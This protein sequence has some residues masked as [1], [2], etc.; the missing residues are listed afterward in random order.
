MIKK[1]LLILLSISLCS[2]AFAKKKEKEFE[3]NTKKFKKQNTK[4]LKKLW[5][6]SLKNGKPSK[7]YYPESSNPTLE[8]D[9]IYVGTHGKVFYAVS[10]ST[11]KII[12]EYKNDEPIASTASTNTQNVFFTD[13]GGHI[14]CL[15]KQSG[16]LVWKNYFGDELLGRPLVDK[17]SL[18]LLKGE[19]EI[20]S[21]ST[22]SGQIK[23]NKSIQTYIRDIT[24]NGHASFIK[25]Q[26]SLYL[27]LA[28]GRLYR[29]NASNGNTMWVKNLTMPLRIFKDI[30]ATVVVNGD[31]LY[32]GGYFGAFYR[33]KKSNGSITWL[34]EVAT[35]FPPLILDDLVVLSDINGTIY[36]IDK[37]DGKQ[38]WFN[39]LESGVLS[40]PAEYDNKI[41]VSTFKKD[42]YLINP[43]TGY[44]IQKISLGQGAIT[45]PISANKKLYVLTNDAKLMA[46]GAY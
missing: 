14:I 31:S 8:N 45:Q 36:G 7:R 11:G 18:Y 5:S 24:M 6:K 26:N 23:W 13:L 16:S 39:E 44:Q 29:L 19:R 40:A 35:G 21:V 32:V 10:T 9:I 37:Q 17:N 33:I 34:S 15:N 27:G 2:S 41:F 43:D 4:V 28:D 22:S 25:D 42:A 30:D 3:F 12:W 38:L 46:L 20:I 1:I